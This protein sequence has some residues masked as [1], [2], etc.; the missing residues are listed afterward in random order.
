LW[1]YRLQN[2]QWPFNVLPCALG[3]DKMAQLCAHLT[4]Y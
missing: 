1:T 2:H 3:G 4:P